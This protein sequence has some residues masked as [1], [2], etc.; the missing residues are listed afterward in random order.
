MY[1]IRHNEIS[2]DM[3]ETQTP[4]G[5]KKHYISVEEAINA[6]QLLLLF[7]GLC[8][9]VSVLLYVIELTHTRPSA[10][11]TVHIEFTKH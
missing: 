8:S 2:S 7:R 10:Q 11:L 1:I 6:E 5:R 3:G 4:T 9:S